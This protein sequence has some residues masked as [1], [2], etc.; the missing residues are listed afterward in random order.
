MSTMRNFYAEIPGAAES[1]ASAP[2]FKVVQPRPIQIYQR[3]RL[4]RIS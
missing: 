3:P 4:S 2:E 1:K